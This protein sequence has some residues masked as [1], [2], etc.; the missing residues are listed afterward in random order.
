MEIFIAICFFSFEWGYKTTMTWIK[1]G[2]ITPVNVTILKFALIRDVSF[3]TT[4]KFRFH[5]FSSCDKQGMLCFGFNLN[6]RRSYYHRIVILA[7]ELSIV[8]VLAVSKGSSPF[9]FSER[10]RFSSAMYT[11]II[12]PFPP[13][14]RLTIFFDVIEKDV[15][16]Q[17]LFSVVCLTE[18]SR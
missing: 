17:K 9:L 10:V 13:S 11:I 3:P 2:L 18:L 4:I 1:C 16:I 15:D 5:A 6:A 14:T 8:I 7:S 12:L